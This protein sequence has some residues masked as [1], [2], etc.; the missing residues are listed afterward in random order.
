M[1]GVSL[2]LFVLTFFTHKINLHQRLYWNCFF[3]SPVIIWFFW[4]IYSWINWEIAGLPPN[5]NIYGHYISRFILP[6]G[7]MWL[8]YYEGCKNLKKITS[9]VLIASALYCFFGILFQ[10]RGNVNLGIRGGEL[11]GNFLALVGSAMTFFACL[12]FVAG[13]IKKKYLILLLF[14]GFIAIVFVSTRKALIG[15]FIILFFLLLSEV[16][17][18]KL[19]SLVALLFFFSIL[20]FIYEYI[21]NYTQIGSRLAELSQMGDVIRGVQVPSYMKFLG[22]RAVHYILGWELFKKSIWTG[23]GLGN[24][25][26][27]TNFPVQLHTEYMVQLC[28]GGIVG[29]IIYLIFY[30]SL[31]N[32]V[33]KTYKKGHK[34]VS[35]MCFGGLVYILFLSISTWT[36][37]N[38][39][40]FSVFGLILSHCLPQKDYIRKV[41]NINYYVKTII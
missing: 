24:F 22:E 13:F 5:V 34:K 23:I 20:I 15:W 4:V 35:V 30:I 36:Y 3:N 8:V 21:M 40:F 32:V 27:L 33:W 38:V 39:V 14:L 11:M 6:I 29:S 26:N 25:Q 1:A 2:I 31:F 12:A 19:S 16:K 9:V 41:N 37:D 28:E 18:R 10:E 7:T 17:I